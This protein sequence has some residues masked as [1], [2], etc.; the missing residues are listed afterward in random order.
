MVRV[1]LASGPHATHPQPLSVQAPRG[2]SAEEKRVKLV[3]ILHETVSFC[4][5]LVRDP[6]LITH[7]HTQKD[8][9][10]VATIH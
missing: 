3:E 2:L 8:F 9:F 5:A 10:Q 4:T 1:Q 7:G 6:R